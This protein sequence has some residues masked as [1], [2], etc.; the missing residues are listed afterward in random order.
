MDIVPSNFTW[1]WFVW[2]F[3]CFNSF[4]ALTCVYIN[5]VFIISTHDPHRR[6]K[7]DIVIVKLSL[8]YLIFLDLRIRKKPSFSFVVNNV[9]KQLFLMINTLTEYCTVTDE[10]KKDWIFDEI[11]YCYKKAAVLDKCDVFFLK[12]RFR[13]RKDE[14]TSL[15]ISLSIDFNPPISECAVLCFFFKLIVQFSDSFFENL[16]IHPAFLLPLVRMR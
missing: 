4:I 16:W 11:S 15:M 12:G 1:R 5:I 10:T 3:N 9:Q 8:P 2:S 14:R 13:V 7:V 6:F